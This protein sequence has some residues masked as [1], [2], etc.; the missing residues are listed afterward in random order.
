MREL[1]RP[2]LGA[3]ELIRDADLKFVQYLA[4]QLDVAHQ[5]QLGGEFG[6][7]QGY[8]VKAPTATAWKRKKGR[9]RFA[10]WLLALGFTSRATVNR[11]LYRIASLRADIILRELHRRVVPNTLA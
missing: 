10:E 2:P 1:A 11:Y 7:G 3:K 8:M 6:F 5:A 9:A 4:Q